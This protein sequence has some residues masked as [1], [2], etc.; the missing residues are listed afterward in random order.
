MWEPWPAYSSSGLHSE[1]A[2]FPQ[3]PASLLLCSEDREKA[4]LIEEIAP[5]E[6]LFIYFFKTQRKKKNK[7]KNTFSTCSLQLGGFGTTCKQL[8]AAFGLTSD[9]AHRC[10]LLSSCI[11]T[12]VL[13]FFSSLCP[14]I[15]FFFFCSL[16]SFPLAVE[17][18]GCGWSS[19]V[20][21]C[22]TIEIM[23]LSLS[24]FTDS[25]NISL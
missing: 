23:S 3:S 11:W 14:V 4:G 24:A 6:I 17:L 22:S 15:A 10:G 9:L 2:F 18:S 5:K 8:L 16:L 19:R 12:R 1:E 7:K 21:R 13:F 25:S 20:L